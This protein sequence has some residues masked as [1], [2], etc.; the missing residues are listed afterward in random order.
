[1]HIAKKSAKGSVVLF[2]GILI[3]TAIAAV[4]SI[5]VARFL[6][7]G[8]FG[9]FSLS[10]VAPSLLQLFTHFGTRSAVTK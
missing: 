2:S 4:A 8:D 7:P 6:G 3:A 10:L 1:M 5:V 9:L